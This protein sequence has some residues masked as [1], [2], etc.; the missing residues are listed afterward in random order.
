MAVVPAAASLS[1]Y[2]ARAEAWSNG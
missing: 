2:V 1:G